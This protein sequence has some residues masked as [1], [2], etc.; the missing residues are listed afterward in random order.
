KAPCAEGRIGTS[1][2][3]KACH[4]EARRCSVGH[5]G[6]DKLAVRLDGQGLKAGIGEI[7]DAVIEGG[8]EQTAGPKVRV[9]GTRRKQGPIFKGLKLRP[10]ASLLIAAWRGTLGLTTFLAA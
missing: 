3:V 8:L 6:N 9:Q 2:R 4:G 1:V 7:T 10:E 5:V